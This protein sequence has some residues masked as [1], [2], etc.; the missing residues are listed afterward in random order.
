MVAPAVQL[1]W[2]PGKLNE[3]VMVTIGIRELKQQAG[4]LVRLVMRTGED[5]QIRDDG[6]I[7][8]LLVTPERAKKERNDKEWATLDQLAAEIKKLKRRPT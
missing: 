5:I 6:K 7:V 1:F 4:K 2:E 8:A 3:A